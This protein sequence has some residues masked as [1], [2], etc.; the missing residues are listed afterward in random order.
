MASFPLGPTPSGYAH[1]T[2]SAAHGVYYVGGSAPS[3]TLANTGPTAYSVRDYFGNV[4]SSGTVSGTT[5]T[6]TAPA[7]GWKPG[8]YRLY[9][10]GTTN[11]ALFGF[12]LGSTNFVLL[13]NDS[14]FHG[15]TAASSPGDDTDPQSKSALGMGTHRLLI[16]DVT[17]T[18]TGA[19]LAQAQTDIALYK[20]YYT[21]PSGDIFYDSVRTRLLWLAFPNGSTDSLSI[22]GMRVYCKDGTIVG[23]NVTV[24]ITTG[25]LS[26]FKITVTNSA[27][28]S[29]EVYDNQA[30]ATSAAAA[31]NAASAI[32]VAFAG[33]TL[34]TA[35]AASIPTAAFNGVKNVVSTLYPDVT[36]FEG[37]SN[38]PTPNAETAQQMRLFQAAVHAGNAGA[39]AIGPCPVSISGIGGYVEPFF[40]AGG[41]AYCDEISVHAYNS[42]TNGDINLGRKSWNDFFAL[43][44]KYGLSSKPVWQTESTQVMTNIYGVYHPR[45]GRVPMLQTLLLEQ[46]GIPRERNVVWYDLSHGF[47]AFPTWWEERDETFAPYVVLF[48]TLA[49]ETFGMN[50]AS[51]LSFGP[52]GDKVFLGSIYGTSG[53]R[54]AVVMTQ[55]AMP[56][57]NGGTGPS[58]T[59]N[60]TGTTSPMTVVDGFGNTSTV[61]VL[62]G[63][64]TIP[65]GETPTYLRI[66]S[67]VSVT[68]D[69][70]ND[71]PSN[72]SA[73][74]S[75]STIAAASSPTTAPV[76]DVC[77]GQWMQSYSG[78][79]SNVQDAYAVGTTVP[80]SVTLQWPSGVRLDR[81][82]LWCGVWQSMS[83]LVDFDIQT[84]NDG[85]TWTTQA[86]VTR[87]TPSSF[88]HGADFWGTGCQRETYWDEQ[89]IHDVKLPAP[90][91]VKYVRL[92]VRATSYGG[93]PDAAATA[94]GGQGNSNQF[95]TLQEM[96][97]L[98]DANVNGTGG[99]G[100]G[101]YGARL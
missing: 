46:F 23:S 85:T 49:E 1:V 25:T 28:S 51:A 94:T 97:V 17:N 6:P 74:L 31:I 69:H 75:Y 3:F 93:E 89:W 4:V 63:K 72:T 57:A 41:G 81:V 7:G 87:P 83:A 5:V 65:A 33:G 2:A 39:K 76:A 82:L 12:A 9:L 37:P 44:A 55:S 8:W 67:G 58:V 20:T 79:G 45:R 53:A 71:W 43:L 101:P 73:W 60:V 48:R 34:A 100:S 54:V 16:S 26:G 19:T 98:C 21:V 22:G 84:S 30:T 56:T 13:R 77:D 14:R 52:I 42:Q 36:R 62:S 91:T 90:V 40:A 80:D 64:V 11:D 47:W 96:A 18:S 86:T 70:C 59:F 88:I 29:T 38:E 92:Y 32:V 50:H 99:G 27:T 15:F 35:A 24:T 61:P 68:V 78:G 95:I 10:T 66:P